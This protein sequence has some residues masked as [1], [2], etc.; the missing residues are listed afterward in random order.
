MCV[1]RRGGR[2][3]GEASQR[4]VGD[5][6]RPA[7]I[8]GFEPELAGE[9]DDCGICL[10]A[11]LDVAVN[12]CRHGL[13]IDCAIRLCE[14]NKKPP[15]CPFCRKFIEGFHTFRAADRRSSPDA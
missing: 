2:G 12:G 1:R 13:C 6:S 11:E 10:E 9:D 4:P 14:V 7:S 8:S 3:N 15:L 5:H